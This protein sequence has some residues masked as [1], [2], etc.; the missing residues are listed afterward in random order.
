M[1][2]A[3][4]DVPPLVA[5]WRKALITVVFVAIATLAPGSAPAQNGPMANNSSPAKPPENKTVAVEVSDAPDNASMPPAANNQNQQPNRQEAEI[6]DGP[7]NGGWLKVVIGGLVGAATVLATQWITARANRA[8][9]SE[10]A[11]ISRSAVQVAADAAKASALGASAAVESAGAARENAA[12]AGRNAD[13]LGVHA[14]ARLRQEWINTVRDELSRL[15]SLLAN[16]RPPPAKATPTQI[17]A[18]EQRQRDTNQSKAKL[19]LLLNPR[20]IP[21]RNLAVV[22]RQLENPALA[23]ADR[24]RWARWIVRWGQILL[25]EEWDRVRAELSG[26]EIAVRFRRDGR[27]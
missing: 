20:E 5:R 1:R 12:V 17:A 9:A 18:S 21:S 26:E 11:E 24:K 6:G 14:V 2:Y 10:Q 23:T 16:Y 3:E 25:K 27:R 15:H 22:I 19:A 7:D 13:N 4:C 8:I